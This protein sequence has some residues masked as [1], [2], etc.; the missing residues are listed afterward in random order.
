MGIPGERG[1]S[2][3][4]GADGIPGPQGKNQPWLLFIFY[5]CNTF[6]N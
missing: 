6:I 4:P 5:F 3:E 2:G 1:Y